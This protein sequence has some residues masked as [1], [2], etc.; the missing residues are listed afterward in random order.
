MPLELVVNQTEQ[1]IE[2]YKYLNV[3][4]RIYCRHCGHRWVA[5]MNQLLDDPECPS[6]GR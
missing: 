2:D 3:P 1:E 5:T 6:C 4:E